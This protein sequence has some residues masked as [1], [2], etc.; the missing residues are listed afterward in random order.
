M[1]THIVPISWPY[2]TPEEKFQKVII[3]Q[4]YLYKFSATIAYFYFL[5]IN[6]AL[7]AEIALSYIQTIPSVMSSTI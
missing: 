4:C 5:N 1:A 7:K 2:P 3:F 6:C